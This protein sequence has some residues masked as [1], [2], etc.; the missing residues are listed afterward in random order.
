[1]KIKLHPYTLVLKEPFTISRGS[2]SERKSLFVELSSGDKCGFGEASEHEYYGVNYDDLLAKASAIL[3]I[4]EAYAFD[5]PTNYWE[6]LRPHLSSS[7]F[8]Q[9]AFDE[10]AHD[11]YG[12]ICGHPCREF[13]KAHNEGLPKTSYTLSIGNLGK[14]IEKLNTLQ[15]DILK[16]KLGTPDDMALLETLRL[17]T[18]A[19]FRVDVNCAWTAEETILNSQRM[20]ELGVEFIEQPLPAGDWEG[21]KKVR[22]NATLPIIADE[23]CRTEDDVEKC[24]AVFHGIN[25][26]LMKCGGITPALR[27]IEKARILSLKVMC[28]CMVESSVGAAAIAQLLPQ[29]DYVDMDGPLFLANDPASGARILQNGTIEMPSSP[30]L[31]IESLSL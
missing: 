28:G 13:W 8:L 1:M 11:L 18:K 16:I 26:K 9:C 27:M 10:A 19:T 31:G 22:A 30:G 23:T 12:K 6:Y 29:L 24:A 3:P 14:L 4:A 25:I 7:P 17:H 21:M 20:K 15:F 5:N 2:Y